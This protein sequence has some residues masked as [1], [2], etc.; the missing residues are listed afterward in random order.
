MRLELVLEINHRIYPK[1]PKPSN[2]FE[3]SKRLDLKFFDFVELK[4]I[5]EK[6]LVQPVASKSGNY[7]IQEHLH[8]T[9][10]ILKV[11]CITTIFIVDQ[12]VGLVHWRIFACCGF[13]SL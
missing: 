5:E 2:G 7:W 3:V 9:R 4:T 11:F 10:G 12:F 6:G 1:G 8:R 13:F